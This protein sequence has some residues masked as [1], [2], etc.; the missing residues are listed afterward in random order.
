MDRSRSPRRDYLRKWYDQTT[1]SRGFLL[2]LFLLILA[3]LLR[4]AIAS[5]EA[6][7]CHDFL[8]HPFTS[9][10]PSRRTMDILLRD[11]GATR[12]ALETANAEVQRIWLWLATLNDPRSKC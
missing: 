4:V 11:L 9:P 12:I 2:S 1:L 7:M 8:S 6:Q 3:L 5:S 10:I